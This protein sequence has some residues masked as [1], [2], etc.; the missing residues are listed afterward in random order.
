MPLQYTSSG[1]VIRP[2]TEDQYVDRGN[3]LMYDA[4]KGSS[5]LEMLAGLFGN[6]QPMSVMGPATVT[7]G[8]R[9]GPV[10]PPVETIGISNIPATTATNTGIQN[11]PIADPG[12]GTPKPT[13]PNTEVPAGPANRVAEAAINTAISGPPAAH[14]PER[15]AALEA[16]LTPQVSPRMQLYNDVMGSPGA[17]LIS[18]LFGRLFNGNPVKA[19]TGNTTS[20]IPDVT[21]SNQGNVL[22]N[23]LLQQI[24]STL[25]SPTP[26]QAPIDVAGIPTQP[27]VSIAPAPDNPIGENGTTGID[28]VIQQLGL[29]QMSTAQVAN[30][31]KDMPDEIKA[32]IVARLEEMQQ[33]LNSLVGAGES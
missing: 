1:A 23:P 12:P 8:G 33:S 11:T 22:A 9:S 28:A 3:G 16:S 10:Y 17:D 24:F 31:M 2:G 19:S 21:G 6:E 15:Q 29:D 27:D 18:Q 30:A 26:Q 14:N 20:P 13:L 4:S 25:T 7:G 5:P 32:Q